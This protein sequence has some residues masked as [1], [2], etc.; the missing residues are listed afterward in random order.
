MFSYLQHF[1]MEFF[2]KETSEMTVVQSVR[3]SKA[4]YYFNE[5]LSEYFKVLDD[6]KIKLEDVDR[7][8]QHEFA[9]F[10]MMFIDSYK[11][12]RK[13]DPGPKTTTQDYSEFYLIVLYSSSKTPENEI[14]Q[15]F[16]YCWYYYTVNVALLLQPEKGEKPILLYTYFPFTP[17][18]CHQAELQIINQNKSILELTHDELY[19]DKFHN[20]HNC[21]LIAALWNVPPYLTLPNSKYSEDMEGMEGFLLKLLAEVLSFQIDYITPPNDEQRGLMKADGTVTGAI[22]M[23]NDR[24]ADLSLGSFRCTQ[25]R[26]TALSPSMTFYQT[27]QVFT[28]LS[29][30]EPWTSFEIIAYPFDLHIWIIL[31]AL[32]ICLLSS[33][34]ILEYFR[35]N[36]LKF[37]YGFSTANYININILAI[38]LGQAVNAV[39]VRNF[40]RYIFLMWVL[41]T[42]IL[43]SIYQGSLYDFL[44]SQ[45]TLAPPDTA[46]ELTARKYKLIVNMATGDS[47]SGVQIIRDKLIEVLIMNI[48]DSGGFSILEAN[49][50]KRYVTGTPKDFL[51]Y[52]VHTHNKYGVFHILKET[53]FSQHLCVYFTK[54]SYLVGIFD[55]VL[56][57]LRSFGLIDY[58]ASLVLD[59]RFLEE[60][61]EPNKETPLTFT[62]LSG[63][64]EICFYLYLFTIVVFIFEVMWF[65]LKN[66]NKN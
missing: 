50:D 54:H 34:L 28:V 60:V 1:K 42:M 3:Y 21:A 24:V 10:N 18:T 40:A 36:I 64:M 2:L 19:P 63:I 4:K 17:K 20:F 16:D 41:L 49:P 59:D 27:M 53:I 65:K 7:N 61:E 48:T 39:P 14:Q 62:Q 9:Y 25:E 57:N 31:L 51:T 55:H 45:K 29:L 15:I 46:A 8:Y 13:I 56:Q 5:L 58:W 11:S 35:C 33:A 6:I 47:F 26:S 44:K 38:T 37:I 32:L 12:F 22:K 30:R 52:Y 43:R 66:R 23:L